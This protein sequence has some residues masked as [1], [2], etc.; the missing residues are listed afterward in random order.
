MK[1]SNSPDYANW[2]PQK[3]VTGLALTAALLSLLFGLSFLLPGGTLSLILRFI[4]GAAALLML[5]MFTYM[6][7]ARKLLSYEG[8]GV[9]G[10]ILDNVL[11]YLDWDG[12]GELLDIGCG[13]GALTIKAARKFPG[14]RCVGMDYWGA[15]WD[16][17]QTQCE[18]NARLEGVTDRVRFQKG[19]AA[20]LDFPDGCFDAA[21]SNFVFHEVRTQPDKLALIREALRVLK[22]GAPFAFEDV[23]F[24]RGHYPDLEELIKTLSGEVAELRF[25]DTR[26][27]DFVPKLLR[28]PLVAGEMGLL[29]GRK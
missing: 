4:L 28:T 3:L 14:A 26:K 5:V 25:M 7:R 24:S 20:K 18:N 6:A 29:C 9:Q 8:G 21:V 12:R 1:P 15:M 27:N 11:R 16:Y 10:K 22:P 17:A 2:I 19:D 23:F 13:S